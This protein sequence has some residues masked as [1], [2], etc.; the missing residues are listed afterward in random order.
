MAAAE[1]AAAPTAAAALLEAAPDAEGAAPALHA[2]Q[3]LQGAIRALADAA[4][5]QPRVYCR[6]RTREEA[7]MMEQV[8]SW[9]DLRRGIRLPHAVLRGIAG[10]GSGG[11]GIGAAGGLG[12]AAFA[13]VRCSEARVSLF[14]PS[15]M[16]EAVYVQ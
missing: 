13:K 5:A 3:R 15:Q 6:T 11:G 4:G 8:P 10:A 16:G 14:T 7:A 1:A 9:D 12:G 2:L